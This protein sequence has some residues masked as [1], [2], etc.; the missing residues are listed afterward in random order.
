MTSTELSNELAEIGHKITPEVIKKDW[1]KGA[2]RSS[3]AAYLSWRAKR[4][5]KTAR[6]DPELRGL[7][8]D[9]LKQEIGVLKERRVAQRRENE[10]ARGALIGRAWMAERVHIAAGRVD[11]YRMKSEAEHPLLFAAAAGDVAA[12]REVVRKIWDEIAVALNGMKEAFRN[13]RAK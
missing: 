7:R 13:E 4:S 2:P 9:K 1:Q 12:C 8:A 3:A 5:E 11:A 10:V 6:G